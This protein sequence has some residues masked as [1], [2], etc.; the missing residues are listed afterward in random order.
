MALITCPECQR[1]ISD[2]AAA[3]PLCGFPISGAPKDAR[4]DA[5]PHV[6]TVRKSRGVYIVLGLL[7]GLLGIHNFYAGYYALAIVQLLV[8]VFLWW[9]IF[10]PLVVLAVVLWE[11]FT[12]ADDAYG[13]AFS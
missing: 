7:F 8:T 1:E 12:T 11:L 9:T 3:C 4:F 2:Q 13:V 5:A 6:V 10:A